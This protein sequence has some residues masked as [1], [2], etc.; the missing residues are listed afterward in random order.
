[1]KKLGTALLL[2]LF[3]FGHSCRDTS[4]EKED[5][6][7]VDVTVEAIEELASVKQVFYALP[8]PVEIAVLLKSSGAAYNED[9]LN[10][11]ENA[12]NYLTTKSIALNLGIYITDLSYAGFFDQTQ[13]SINYMAIS[14][15]LA[16]RLGIMDA[17]DRHTLEKLEANL[18]NRDVVMDI[19]SE[20]YLNSSAFLHENERETIATMLF[21]GG[22]IEGLFIATSLA[23]KA[24]IENN[25]LVDHIV[26]QKHSLE[27]LIKLLENNRHNDDVA[28]LYGEIGEIWEI[29]EQI[30]IFSSP[31]SVE[32]DEIRGTAV[33]SSSREVNITRE[34]FSDLKDKVE[35]I[36]NSFVSY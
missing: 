32:D 6:F 26:D 31:V 30:E 17:V 11:V 23:D 14:K 7:E 29:Y 27:L 22:F 10:P 3:V 8:S 1:M 2:V 35:N 33:L 13:A 20:T 4:K 28:D 36:R 24:D 21:A 18:N 15:E 5:E 25:A 16:E 34:Q 9:L 19:I 12:G